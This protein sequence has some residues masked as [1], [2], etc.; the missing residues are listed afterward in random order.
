M[1]GKPFIVAGPCSAESGVQV[2]E[3]AFALKGRADMFRAGL[4][5]PR[6]SPGAFEGVGECGLAW[7]QDARDKTGL[8]VCTEVMCAAHVRLC[9]ETGIDAVWLGARTTSNPY[10]VQEIADALKGSGLKVF[11]KNPLSPDAALWAGAVRRL[12]GCDVTLV[13]RGFTP[14]EGGVWRNDPRWGVPLALRAEF[15]G[16]PIL[17]DPSHMAG[18]AA[19]VPEAAQ[20]AMDLGFDG[21]MVEVHPHPE[22]ALTDAAQQL[23][24]EGFA[25]MLDSL[26]CRTP[27]CGTALEGLRARI[28]EIDSDIVRSLAER[29]ALSRKI[30][31]WKR[32]N[33]VQ[34]VQP[35][36]WD[37][38]MKGVYAQARMLGVS[39]CLVRE[40]FNLIHE[41]SVYNQK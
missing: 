14:I 26:T 21:L 25:R 1:N 5:K 15:S 17:C 7:L 2:L 38:V 24:P 33:G 32:V 16:M 34:I 3:A 18:N 30:G 31:E 28:D 6:T 11:V 4:W 35:G 8:P 20:K 40:I 37:E 39:E 9:L 29:M 12:S 13:H 41:E 10:L 36:R 22:V 27:D 23:S 19:L